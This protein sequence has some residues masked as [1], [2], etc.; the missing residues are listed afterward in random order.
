M[1]QG[2]PIE[3]LTDHLASCPE[4]FLAEP[5]HPNGSGDI[6][7]PAVVSDLL[8]VLE[9]D[10]PLSEQEVKSFQYSSRADVK[11]E[12]NHLRLVLVACWLCFVGNG[13][14]KKT[15][16]LV[17]WFLRGLRKISK[18][19]QAD[20]FVHDP[21]RR[22][23]LC[24]LYLMALKELPL[25]ESQSEAENKLA[26]LDTVKRE[27]VVREAKKSQARANKLRE[28]MAAAEKARRAASVYSHE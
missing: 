10:R 9:S 8:R 26:A 15:H 3:K 6:S 1:E 7:V 25:G 14:N 4:I 28:K 5:R 17:D 20:L 19:V 21:E 23:E 13:G 16:V 24:R 18:L 27:S 11:K 12:R 22:E 2:R